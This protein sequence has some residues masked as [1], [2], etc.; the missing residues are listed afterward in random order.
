MLWF[1][2]VK[3]SKYKIKLTDYEVTIFVNSLIKNIFLIK[4]K[5]TKALD[6]VTLETLYQ[7]MYALM[8]V[9]IELGFTTFTNEYNARNIANDV[10]KQL[11]KNLANNFSDEDDEDLINEEE[12]EMDNDSVNISP[13]DCF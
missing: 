1:S 6:E 12:G 13:F 8:K 10:R 5:I 11:N 3:K 9:T 7:E 2:K 4:H